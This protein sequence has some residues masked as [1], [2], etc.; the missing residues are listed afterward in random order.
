[1][2]SLLLEVDNWS[3]FPAL[4]MS[5]FIF[6]DYELDSEE[7]FLS[8]TT[9]E[10]LPYF[11]DHTNL[12]NITAPLGSTA[13]L[14]CKVNLLQDKTV[15]PF[16]RIAVVRN[17]FLNG[18]ARG[19]HPSDLWLQEES[20]SQRNRA[21]SHVRILSKE[22]KTG[23]SVLYSMSSGQFLSGSWTQ[24]FNLRNTQAPVRPSTDGIS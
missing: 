20:Q 19:S 1:M 17:P 2:L 24:D 7:M 22:S 6:S 9:T 18:D 5:L 8:T 3:S 16:L 23:T 13:F 11:D 15:S 12:T 10:P 21:H 4:K 14:H